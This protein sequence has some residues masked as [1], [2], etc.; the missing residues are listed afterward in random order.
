MIRFT[1]SVDGVETLNRS[2][3][4][5]DGFIADMR[6]FAPGIATEFYRIEREQFASEGAAGASGKW[7]PLS[8]AYERFKAQAFPGETILRATGHMEASLTDPDALD[9]IYSAERDQITFGTKDPK[10]VA[11]HRGSGH[12]PSRPVISMS[13]TQKRRIQKAIQREL[14]EFTRRAG[15]QVE[16][17]AA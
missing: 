9:A 11:H 17:R 13:E 8:K 6:N 4:R 5:V 12:L 7:T 14:V 15:F 10:A 2:F 3:N 16:E 1:A